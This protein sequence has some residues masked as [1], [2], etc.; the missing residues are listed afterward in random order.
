MHEYNTCLLK[1]YNI[2]CCNLC[3]FAEFMSADAATYC[4]YTAQDDNVHFQQNP[5]YATVYFMRPKS[6]VYHE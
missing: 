3:C 2:Q 6:S 1:L 5:A 4:T